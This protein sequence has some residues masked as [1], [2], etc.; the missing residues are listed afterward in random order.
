MF[1]HATLV[2]IVVNALISALVDYGHVDQNNVPVPAAD[3]AWTAFSWRN[4]LID[5]VEKPFLVLFTIEMVVKV[6]WCSRRTACPSHCA[7]HPLFHYCSF[8][9]VIAEGF[10]WGYNSYLSNGWNWIDF[11]VVASGW[12]QYIP[13]M[14]T[15]SGLRVLRAMRPLR[16][17]TRFPAMRELVSGFLACLGAMGDV[18]AMMVSATVKGGEGMGEGMVR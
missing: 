14:P 7:A 6:R 9:Q 2:A 10:C 8:R 13:G 5:A 3:G 12:A 4:N 16:S 1:E 11:V 18:F 17:V 15:A